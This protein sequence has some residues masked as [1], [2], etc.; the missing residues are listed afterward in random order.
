MSTAVIQTC[1]VNERRSVLAGACPAVCARRIG[2]V[3]DTRGVL[4]NICLD[5]ST[6]ATVALMGSN[7][8]GKSTLLRILATLIPPTEGTLELFGEKPG[9]QRRV[10]SRIGFIGH[11][12]MLYRDLTAI[13][14]L[15]LFGRLYGL[16]DVS[17]RALELLEFLGIADRANDTVK[18]L[19]R[20][21]V[22]RVAIARALMHSPDLLLADEPFAGLDAGSTRRLED[23]LQS[24]RS[25][26]HAV[27]MASH[28]VAQAISIADRLVVLTE[29]RIALEAVATDTNAR[30]ISLAMEGQA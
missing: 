12:P 23:C 11:R 13:E 29:G 7:G 6:H 25:K 4:S 22:Q 9:A 30:S 5:I 3:I 14:N 17:N 18:S 8:A 28:N 24:L 10:R 1:E 2:K 20:G 15:E 19:S 26:G 16:Q 27:V 21:L